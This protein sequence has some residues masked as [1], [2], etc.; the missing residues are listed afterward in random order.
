MAA[1]VAGAGGGRL[2]DTEDNVTWAPFCTV[3]TLQCCNW[4]FASEFKVRRQF[5][6]AAER[7]P[8]AATTASSTQ[9]LRSLRLELRASRQSYWLVL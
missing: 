5:W 6:S 9:V 3:I 1:R 7:S 4:R 2:G 8:S